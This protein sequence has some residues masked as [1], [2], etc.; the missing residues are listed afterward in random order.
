MCPSAAFSTTNPS[1]T[2]LDSNPGLR[3]ERP[4][5]K[6]L[7][8]V[9]IFVLQASYFIPRQCKQVYYYLGRSLRCRFRDTRYFVRS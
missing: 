3:G 5:M 6:R 2:G 8:R 9:Q 4:T 7:S 1:L